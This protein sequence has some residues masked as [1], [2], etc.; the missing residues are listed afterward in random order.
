M[1]SIFFLKE[2]FQNRVGT[3]QKNLWQFHKFDFLVLTPTKGRWI[4]VQ[5]INLLTKS[6]L[7]CYAWLII[8]KIISLP[9]PMRNR[10]ERIDYWASRKASIVG[11]PDM[12]IRNIRARNFGYCPIRRCD[13]A[14]TQVTVLANSSST[15][16]SPYDACVRESTWRHLWSIVREYD[17]SIYHCDC[18]FFA[19]TCIVRG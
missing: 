10:H 2:Y 1:K 15:R 17:F 9:H 14:E 6:P 19:S 11:R 4:S 13:D 18:L 5:R 3:W 12:M 8:V 16:Q 7:W